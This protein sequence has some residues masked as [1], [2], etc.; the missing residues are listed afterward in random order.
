MPD[1]AAHKSGY[2][3]PLDRSPYHAKER[4]VLLAS[5]PGYEQ[6]VEHFRQLYNESRC[7][8]NDMSQ[9]EI[10]LDSVLPELR[11][12]ARTPDASEI[13]RNTESYRERLRR[14]K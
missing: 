10:F 12:I 8:Y 7:N 1:I 4:W 3:Q 6:R 13:L 9:V 5:N 14:S 11:E 2:A